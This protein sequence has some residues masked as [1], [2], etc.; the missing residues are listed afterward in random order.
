[1]NSSFNSG[2]NNYEQKRQSGQS[3]DGGNV[4]TLQN[5]ENRSQRCCLTKAPFSRP[6]R[7][8]FPNETAGVMRARPFFEETKETGSRQDQPRATMAL[9]EAGNLAARILA[10][11]DTYLNGVGSANDLINALLS[12][13]VR[14][15]RHIAKEGSIAVSKSES[16]CSRRAS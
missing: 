16:R 1:M 4:V 15:E 3:N 10:S 5:G 12:K 9:R 11:A 13:E 8:W 2:G 6:E 7:P 14:E